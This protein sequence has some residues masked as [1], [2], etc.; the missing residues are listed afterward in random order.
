M[1]QWFLL[2]L[3]CACKLHSGAQ[4]SLPG[5]VNEDQ[6][7]Y[8]NPEDDKITGIY[9]NGDKLYQGYKRKENWHGQWNS[10]YNNGQMIDSGLMKMGIPDKTWTGWY[11]DGNLQFIRTYS[12]EKWQQFQLEKLRYHPKGVSL[13]LTKLYHEN[14][15]QVEKYISAKNSFC[16]KSSCTRIHYED[17]S[18]KINSNSAGD[19]YHPLFE[20]GILHGPFVNYFSNGAVKDSGN[21]KNGLP[22][23]LWIKWTDDKQFYWEGFYQHGMKNKEWKLYSANNKLIRIVAYRHGRYLWKND[24]KEGFETQEEEMSGF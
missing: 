19:H 18:Q 4:L 3:F 9:T 12:A 17:L 13:P 11:P 5:S 23:G 10:W 20:N 7:I 21:Y 16:V 2:I 22:E 14:K 24:I 1:K 15:K 6:S 8:T